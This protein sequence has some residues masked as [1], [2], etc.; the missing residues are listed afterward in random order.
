MY[1][2]RLCSLLNG[3]DAFYYLIAILHMENVAHILLFVPPHTEES[4][5]GGTCWL[6]GPETDPGSY[7]RQLG[8]PKGF[9]WNLDPK[10][11][12]TYWRRRRKKAFPANFCFLAQVTMSVALKLLRISNTMRLQNLS[13]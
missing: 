6:P 8:R 3:S 10:R 7:P 1:K 12:F 2:N 11:A 13:T 5:M 4:N 9:G